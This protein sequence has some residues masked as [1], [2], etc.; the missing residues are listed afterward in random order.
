LSSLTNLLVDGSNRAFVTDRDWY[1]E[2]EYALNGTA[3]FA[4]LEEIVLKD[5]W[6]FRFEVNNFM[7]NAFNRK[8]GQLVE[9]GLADVYVKNATK[10]LKNVE[11]Q[12]EHVVLTMEHLSVFFYLWLILLAIG[13]IIFSLEVLQID[14]ILKNF[15]QQEKQQQK[16]YVSQPIEIQIIKP[17]EYQF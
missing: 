5:H 6:G 1:E 12:E 15:C 3:K 8:I 11:T 16:K 17:Q 2:L 9:S 13:V 4:I 10:K 14:E 7:Y